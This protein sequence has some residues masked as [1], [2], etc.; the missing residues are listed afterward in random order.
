MNS[1][2]STW[3]KWISL[4]S[5]L[6]GT[7]RKLACKTLRS[8]WYIHFSC[9]CQCECGVTL[10]SSTLFLHSCHSLFPFNFFEQT[11]LYLLYSGHWKRRKM[12]KELFLFSRGSQLTEG[13][14]NRET[15]DKVATLPD[16]TLSRALA[17][18]TTT[19]L[20]A[21]KSHA[22]Q[23]CHHLFQDRF[24]CLSVSRVSELKFGAS[25]AD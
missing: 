1:H 11:C 15:S 14:P 25:T 4:E 8:D 5:K 12:C 20:P 21:D 9:L 17:A 22:C 19:Q 2:P 24:P 23:D 10:F 18:G 3:M 7:H 13:N 6:K 16:A